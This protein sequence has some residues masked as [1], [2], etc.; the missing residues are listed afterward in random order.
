MG[1]PLTE[2]MQRMALPVRPFTTS[3]ATKAAVIDAL[4][5]GF[6]RGDIRIIN[7]PVLVAELQA[8][9]M[10]RLPSGLIRYTAPDGMHDDCVIG[11]ALA[12]QAVANYIPLLF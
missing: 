1:G 7:D 3:N 6:E 4:A 10:E 9:E 8:Y 2:A 5:L 12:W 11:L